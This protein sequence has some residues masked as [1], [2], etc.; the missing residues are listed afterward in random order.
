M[1]F[2]FILGSRPPGAETGHAPLQPPPSPTRST[3]SRRRSDMGD[4]LDVIMEDGALAPPRPSY[5]SSRRPSSQTT[6][7]P[8]ADHDRPPPPYSR[9]ADPLDEEKPQ[10]LRNYKAIAR[11]GGWGRC[12]VALVVFAVV[13]VALAVGLTVGLRKKNQRD[14]SPATT[15]SPQSTSDPKA[16]FP[17]GSYSFETFLQSVDTSCI[18]NARAWTCFPFRTYRESSEISTITFNWIIET[19][20]SSPSNYSITSSENPFAVSFQS[21]PLR[22]LDEGSPT[23][24]YVFQLETDKIVIPDGSIGND[25][26]RASCYYNGTTFDAALYT[27]RSKTDASASAAPSPPPSPQAGGAAFRPWPYAV[28]V[29]Q[30]ISGRPNVPTCYKLVNGRQGEPLDVRIG[31]SGMCSCRYQDLSL[32]MS[33]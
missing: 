27:R 14:A 8:H 4:R 6:A 11:R 5:L 10:G 31:A 7:P 29:V 22:L 26:F 2:T 17:Q 12:L 18:T 1:A 3:R 24:R 13:I 23:E 25:P 20:S 15:P 28:Q 9:H 21:V 32:E 30:S 19:S 16:P 33:G